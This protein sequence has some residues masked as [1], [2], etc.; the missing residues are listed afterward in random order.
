V[1]ADAPKAGTRAAPSIP[2][3]RAI[4]AGNRLVTHTD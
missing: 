2:K 4:A 3:E 1:V